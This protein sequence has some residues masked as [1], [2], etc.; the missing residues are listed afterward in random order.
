NG[1][2]TATELRLMAA[3]TRPLFALADARHFA[4]TEKS[5]DCPIVQLA[6]YREWLAYGSRQPVEP[7][8]LSPDSVQMMLFTSGSTARPRAAMIRSGQR[9][10]N[11]GGTAMGWELG[12]EDCAIQAAPCFHAALN[13][14]T[15]PLLAVGGRVVLM[16]QF[17][18]GEYLRLAKSFSPT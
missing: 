11:A 10:A 12:V 6:D 7:P 14:L 1:R 13:V 15:T 3:Q 18:P 2:L 17:D 5:F 8:P 9:A 4:L 16:S